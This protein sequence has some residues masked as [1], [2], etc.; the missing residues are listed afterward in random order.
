M[1]NENILTIKNVTKNFGKFSA[2]KNVTIE[3]K[4]GRIIGLLGKNGAG[5]TT[6]IKT[7]LGLYKDFQGE[8][9]YQ[10]TLLNTEDH[11][12]MSSIGALVDTKFHEDLTAYD[13]LM[14]LLMASKVSRAKERKTRINEILEL[15]GLAGNAK[16]KVKSFSMGMKQ[17]LALAQALMVEA[18][19]LILDEPFVGLDPL[20]IELIKKKL[21]YLCHKENV[22][23]IFSSH[24]LAEVA[25]LSEDI[26][27]INEGEISFNGLYEN[28]VNDTKT[29]QVKVNRPIELQEEVSMLPIEISENRKEVFIRKST[30]S[31]NKV[32]SCLL[33]SGF[34][35]IDIEVQ[36]NAL[37]QL[38]LET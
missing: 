38:F 21:L 34:E 15:V 4:E 25:E 26:I 23:I 5:K 37:L 7:I 14:L 31:L 18:K 28:L 10:G 24:Q 1:K 36:E 17:R 12:V 30:D 22:S 29:Y 13:N 35:I 19:L 6:L 8:I 27:V 9:F 16:D 3:I 33:N 32:L 20:G 11:G 2:L